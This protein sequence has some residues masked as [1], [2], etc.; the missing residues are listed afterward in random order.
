MFE[1]SVEEFITVKAFEVNLRTG[2]TGVV[3][4]Y[5]LL[6]TFVGSEQN[7]AA[8]TQIARTFVTSQG[9]RNPTSIPASVVTPVSITPCETRSFYVTITDTTA[10]D[11][12]YTRGDITTIDTGDTIVTFLTSVATPYPFA[13]TS[14]DRIWNGSI[15]YDIIS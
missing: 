4:I 10:N 6:G 14:S 13:A 7:A 11:L 12:R 1:I 8:W 2:F 15:L 9:E 3:E 5:T